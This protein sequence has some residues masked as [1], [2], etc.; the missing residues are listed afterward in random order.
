MASMIVDA[1]EF[2]PE[3]HILYTRPKANQAGGKSVG[4]LN[5]LSKKALY[6]NSPLMMT[7]GA[8]EFEGNGKFDMS[9]QFPREEFTNPAITQFLK[10][11][12]E[13]ENKIKRDARTNSRDWFGKQ[14]LSEDVVEALFSP[15]LKYRK[16]QKTGE[17]DKT[18]MPTLKVKL[19]VWQGEYKFELFDTQNHKLLPNDKGLT[20]V[21]LIP[22][23]CEVACILVCGGIWFANG[24]F[25]LTWKAYQIVV[26]PT[27]TLTKGQCHIK[28]GND[29]PLRVDTTLT[30][31]TYDSDGE[32]ENT[33]TTKTTTTNT[34]ETVTDAVPANTVEV[35]ESETVS[36]VVAEKPK[37]KVSK[38]KP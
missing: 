25:G 38:K 1:S 3:Q 26:K 35:V 14:S 34:V 36:E 12:T 18:S 16:D 7:W 19:P 20:L 15:M 33:I 24:K 10:V 27:E 9:L 31:P 21:D 2:S 23:C 6:L 30:E 13:F 22:K 17:P 4:I 32:S 8:A 37:V 29:T 28:L 5:T 11:L